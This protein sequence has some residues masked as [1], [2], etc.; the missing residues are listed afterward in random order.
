MINILEG[1][2]YRTNTVSHANLTP[3]KGWDMFDLFQGGGW[4]DVK[5]G[6]I[7][8]PANTQLRMKP[9]LVYKT[10][11]GATPGTFNNRATLLD[12]INKKLDKKETVQV[13]V[14]EKTS[15]KVSDSLLQVFDGKSWKYVVISG[16][17]TVFT[18]A[19]KFR[20]RPDHYHRVM[21]LD[22]VIKGELEFYDTDE[23]A[24]YVDNR[25]RTNGLNFSVTKV[26]YL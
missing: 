15:S 24:K 21:T 3:S 5:P 26:K 9:E 23:L 11:G 16:N 20:L 10:H 4:E 2:Q 22:G 7:T 17:T 19:P 8:F 14:E 1:V 12:E 18:Y 25:I 13:T 6:E